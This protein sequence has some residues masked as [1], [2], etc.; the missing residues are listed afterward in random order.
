[1]TT[2]S[3]DDSTPLHEATDLTDPT[4]ERAICWDCEGPIEEGQ[5]RVKGGWYVHHLCQVPTP[6]GAEDGR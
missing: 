1:M 5:G 6:E 2:T 4:T 3:N